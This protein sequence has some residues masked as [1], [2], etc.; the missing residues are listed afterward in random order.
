MYRVVIT[1]RGDSWLAE[2]GGTP[3]HDALVELV[4]PQLEALNPRALFDAF[5]ARLTDRRGTALP[6]DECRALWRALRDNG[7]AVAELLAEDARPRWRESRIGPMHTG[8]DATPA[9]LQEVPLIPRR[10]ADF[11]R[12]RLTHLVEAASGK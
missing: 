5:C 6:I 9:Q 7:L 12:T 4:A 1:D 3:T 8:W 11:I 10:V 2:A